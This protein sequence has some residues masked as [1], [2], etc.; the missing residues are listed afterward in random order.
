MAQPVYWVGQDGNIY[1]GSG[2]DGAGV[3]NLGQQ[4]QP[5]V[6]SANYIAKR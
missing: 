5:G 2:V 6:N 3:Q 1:Y 4:F